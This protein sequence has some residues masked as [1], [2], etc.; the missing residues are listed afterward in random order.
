MMLNVTVSTPNH[1]NF[2]AAVNSTKVEGVKLQ[3]IAHKV[4]LYAERHMKEIMARDA[5]HPTG[6]T[7]ASIEA[8]PGRVSNDVAEYHVGSWSR[9]FVLKVF[10]RGRRGFRAKHQRASGGEGALRFLVG[11]VGG[12]IVF[13]QSVKAAP[14]MHVLARASQLA[15]SQFDEIIKQE[16]K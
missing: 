8:K 13:R 7:E 9:G 6:Q 1:N 14:G 12:E 15:L 16:M 4:A 10:D 11:G 5:K 3:R 2:I